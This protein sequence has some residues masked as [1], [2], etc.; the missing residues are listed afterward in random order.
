M[1]APLKLGLYVLTAVGTLLFGTFFLQGWRRSTER[2]VGPVLAQPLGSTSSPSAAVSGKPPGK[3]DSGA[4]KDQTATNLPL[5]TGKATNAAVASAAEGEAGAATNEVAG[6][7]AEVSAE[8]EA[9]PTRMQGGPRPGFGR[10]II[11][12]LMA[13]VSLIALGVLIAYDISQYTAQRATQVLFNDRG[14]DPEDTEY[15][16]IEKVY[17]SGEYLETVRLLRDF[18]AANPRAVHAQLRIAEIYE[19]DLNNPLAAALEYEEVLKLSLEPNRRGWTAIHLVNLYN[20]LDRT[21]QAVALMQQICLECPGTPAAGKARER[22]E[23]MG[24][25]VPEDLPPPS[26]SGDASPGG[27]PRGF[28]KKR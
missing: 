15:E 16:K 13:V 8:N 18:L 11:D 24:E 1:K 19:K 25:A 26:D 9:V 7:T 10:M 22:L 14:P 23:A 3:E 12:G 21:A 28:K 27:L 6:G 20:R 2:P 17:A 5:V 4:G